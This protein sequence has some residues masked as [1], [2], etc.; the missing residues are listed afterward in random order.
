METRL[1]LVLASMLIFFFAN[2]VMADSAGAALASKLAASL[3]KPWVVTERRLD[4]L[5]EGHYWGQKYVGDRGEE[6]L[7]Q[8]VADVHVLWQDASGE[9]RNEVVGKE[10]L[11]LYVM[12]LTYR[13]SLL[14]FFIPQRPVTARLLVETQ[15]VKIYAHPS[16]RIIEKEKLERIVK[17][18]KAIRWPDSPESTGMLSWG[19]WSADISRLLNQGA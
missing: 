17:E 12:P 16:F 10:A 2:D 15:S 5:P 4:V 14:R 11:K 9:W 7:L 3:P 1:W 8:G 19:T 6:V 13:E 18:A